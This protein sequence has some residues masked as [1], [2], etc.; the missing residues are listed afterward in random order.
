MTINVLQ[1]LCC[2]NI[3]QKLPLLFRLRRKQLAGNYSSYLGLLGMDYQGQL[4]LRIVLD[5]FGEIV[6]VILKYEDSLI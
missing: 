2:R 1:V 4:C 5:H 6:Q 3:N